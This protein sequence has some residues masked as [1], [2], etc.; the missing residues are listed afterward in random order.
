[1]GGV[2]LQ[3][4]RATDGR[5]GRFP[6]ADSLARYRAERRRRRSSATLSCASFGFSCRS[7]LPRVVSCS[8][9][10]QP[11]SLQ[12]S[13]PAGAPATYSRA[14]DTLPDQYGAAD[15]AAASARA[16]AGGGRAAAASAGAAA[17]AGLLAS[18]PGLDGGG[19]ARARGSHAAIS[20][21]PSQ[22]GGTIRADHGDA[23]AQERARC[24]TPHPVDPP[25][26]DDEEA[27]PGPPAAARRALCQAWRAR[28]PTAATV[29]SGEPLLD[30]G[31]Q[32]GPLSVS[33][34]GSMAVHLQHPQTCPRSTALHLLLQGAAA[35]GGPGEAEVAP[36]GTSIEGPAGQLLET[37]FAILNHFRA[38]MATFKVQENTELLVQFR[39]NSECWAASGPCCSSS[40]CACSG[41]H[42]ICRRPPQ[43]CAL[44]GD[45]LLQYCC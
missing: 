8:R 10:A 1:M 23:A 41:A 25:A 43:A 40:C 28:G 3:L 32:L 16:H 13:L 29:S 14:L 24:G 4:Y 20:S 35:A 5:K 45:E 27:E 2:G 21:R 12:T 7:I 37:N 18:Q 11:C 26:A 34:S 19:A 36:A 22:R 31:C 42:H 15:G 39:D 6:R 9:A 44:H 33:G 30:A 38:N 17:P